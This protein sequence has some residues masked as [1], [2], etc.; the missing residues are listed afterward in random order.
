[1]SFTKKFGKIVGWMGRSSHQPAVFQ[2]RDSKVSTSALLAGTS[3]SCTRR[4]RR[5]ILLEHLE[6]RQL[7]ATD[8]RIGAVYIE[9]D[10]GTDLEPDKFYISFLGGAPNTQLKRVVLNG[11]LYQPGLSRGDMI[12]D[13]A[14][15]GLGSD[16]FHSFKIESLEAQSSSASVKAIVIDGSSQLILELN[17]FFAGDKLI[18]SIDVDEVAHLKD[19]EKDVSKI[20]EGV[21]PIAS[22]I[23]FQ[24]TLLTAD[25][26]APHFENASGSAEFINLYD[27]TLDP[28][29]LN[30][31]RDND[32]GRRDRTTGVGFILKQTPKPVSLAGTVWVDANEDLIIGA[33]E[34]R[35]PNVTVDLFRQEDAQYVFTGYRTVTD[36][37]GRYSFGVTLGIIPGIYQIRQTQ[38]IGYYSVGATTGKLQSGQPAGELVAGDADIVTRIDLNLGDTHAVDLNFAENL[39]SELGGY[40]CYVT[41]G[42]DCFSAD[43]VKAPQSGVLVELLDGTG[44]VV[45]STRTAVDGTY[46]FT[47]LRAGTY[48]VR[49]TN[50]PGKIDG[51]AKA[52]N[53]GGS[54]ADA[55]N[56][57]Q[58]ILVGGATAQNYNFCDLVP[59]EISGHTYLD[60]NNNGLRDS[61]EEALANVRVEIRN[62]LGTVVGSTLSD[63]QGFYSFTGL[64]PGVYRII[65]QTPIGYLA[66][67]ASAGSLGGKTDSTGDVISAIALGSAAKGIDYDFGELLVSSLAGSVYVDANGDCIRQETELP[68]E[69]VTITLLNAAGAVVAVAFTD[70][71][72][73]YLFDNLVAG[74]YT[75]RE[76]QPAGYLQGGQKAG[77]GGGDASLEDVISAIDIESGEELVDYD[78]CEQEPGSISGTVFLDS[79][80]DCLQAGNEPGLAGVRVELLDAT[81]QLLVHTFTDQQGKYSFGNLKPGQYAVRE[82]QPN[83]YFQGG[84]VAPA[85]GGDASM[86]DLIREIMVGSGQS[87]TEANFCEVA[88]AILSGYVFQDGE[89]I[90]SNSGSL[91]ANIDE[92]RDGLRTADDTPIAGVRLR[93]Y[94][95]Q[96]K[97][98]RSADLLTGTAVTGQFVEAVTDAKGYYEFVGLPPGVYVLFETQPMGYVDYID[99]PGTAGGF[100][101]NSLPELV[102]QQ[103]SEDIDTNLFSSLADG[104][105]KDAIFAIQLRPA[106]N[107]R[108]N[109]FSELKL[110]KDFSF[111][112]DPR[113][114]QDPARVEVGREQFP[115]PQPLGFSPLV[116]SP[117]P[118]ILGAGGPS[119]VT[120]HLS[121]INGGTP[122]GSRNGEELTAET[123]VKNADHLNF[124]AWTVRG[125]QTGNYRYVSL[126]SQAPNKLHSVFYVPGAKPLMGDFNGDSYDE[127]TLFLDGEWF[128]DANGNGRWDEADVWLKLGTKGDQPVIG[129]WD[130]DG[131]DDVGVFGKRWIGDD[132]ALATEPG[133][134]DPDHF[135]KTKRPKNIP[136]PVDEVPET[137]RLMQP[138]RQGR[139]R[140]DVID[141]VFRMGSSRDIAISGQFNEDG[142]VAT[143]GTF[144]NG[145]WKLDTTGDGKPNKSIEFGQAGDLPLVGDFINQ[146]GV[147]EIAIVRGNKV[148]VDSNHNGQID[149]TDQVFLLESAEGTVIVGDFDGDGNDEPALYQTP[150]QQRSLQAR[151]GI[152]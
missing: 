81:G 55:N 126:S 141:H 33:S 62:A 87:I 102:S 118:L 6:P 71:D 23:E 9:K 61:G 125:M 101:V 151:R 27:N 68:L 98:V 93:L 95:G 138:S 21:D 65:E 43:S 128:I 89:V 100:V 42:M 77:S 85:T 31:P 49:Q 146:D 96:G 76:T 32:N 112:P 40:V 144:R 140:A 28:L 20:N 46:S 124:R 123:I 69:G 139:A 94:D 84:Q 60:S 103:A 38:P 97:P 56:I 53:Q 107:S 109:N 108:E 13:T 79:D 48:A 19:G 152:E 29:G 82:L 135:V 80:T 149:V 131:K 105:L 92:L 121:I 70:N 132:R 88:P 74:R 148:I 36:D 86:Q 51:S 145:T 72:G 58:V 142:G 133:L 22:G 137:P 45:R 30:L 119:D 44:K 122:R 10:S 104:Q 12:F 14:S 143:I 7:M 35:L 110:D 25:F 75:V 41:S 39:P 4:R 120:W 67:Q 90:I 8:V 117:L 116:W 130:G 3:C 59:A 73:R 136:R 2:P 78:F 34:T 57:T 150:D 134:P 37:Q 129:D 11:D 113:T 1:M 115:V 26:T 114:P 91:P 16:E 106:A 24:E 17:N 66:G 111:P 18:F 47:G 63:L 99:T 15:G 54:V 52:G 5:S 147:D 50:E 64:R 83:G 127:L